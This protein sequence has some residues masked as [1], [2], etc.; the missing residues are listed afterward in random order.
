MGYIKPVEMGLQMSESINY[1]LHVNDAMIGVV[2]KVLTDASKNGLPGKHC[3]YIT[4]EIHHP[5]VN[6]GDLSVNPADREMTIVLQN[7][8]RDLVVHEDCFSVT[9]NF[10]DEDKTLQ[11]PF[12]AIRAF[13]D[14]SVD[15]GLRFE[16]TSSELKD[17]LDE[18]EANYANTDDA[19]HATSDENVISL[20]RYRE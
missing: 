1:Q 2:R 20:N 8:F 16:R 3:F 9:L 13:F 19:E 18:I 12:D 14:P 7:Y 10:S 4:F 5:D 15:F 17:K 11:I 6:I